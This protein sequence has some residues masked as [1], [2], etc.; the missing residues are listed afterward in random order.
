[1]AKRP[2]IYVTELIGVHDGKVVLANNYI[3]E[4][5]YQALK[6]GLYQPANARLEIYVLKGRF[7]E[8]LDSV[9]TLP[10]D[11]VIDVLIDL[12]GEEGAK[13]LVRNLL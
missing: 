3:I 13:Q 12:H 4:L 11:Q 9:Y 8:Y 10:I 2:D 6:W 1:M 5:K 7:Y